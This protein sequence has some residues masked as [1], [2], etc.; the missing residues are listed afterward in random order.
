LRNNSGLHTRAT[1]RNLQKIGIPP[2][3]LE[4]GIELRSQELLK[5]FQKDVKKQS[6]R[7][8]RGILKNHHMKI[9]EGTSGQFILS[10]SAVRDRIN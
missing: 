7:T 5:E 8:S 10:L 1:D 6:E 9:Q 2:E 4:I 3:F